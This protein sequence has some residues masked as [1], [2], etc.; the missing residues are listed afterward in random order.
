V[1][2]GGDYNLIDPHT[3][4]VVA[5]QNAAEVMEKIVGNA[6]R[7]GD[8]GIVFIDRINRDNPTP[9][10]GD[11]ES[12][13]PCGEQPLLPYESCNLG[14]INLVKFTKNGKIN[15]RELKRVVHSAV[16]F[17][18]NVIDMNKYPIEE[19]ENQTKANRKIGLGIMAFADMLVTLGI[20]YNSEAA[21]NI[22]EELMGFINKES[23]KASADLAKKR[24]AFPN[25]KGSIY[26]KPGAPK[27]RNATTT[28]IAPTGTISI[29][30]GVS[31]GIEPI[32]AVSYIRTVMDDDKL[33]EVHP[34]FERMAMDR[35]FYSKELMETIAFHGTVKDLEEVPKDIADLFITSHDVTPEWHL[36]MQAAFQKHT[37]NA[38]SKTVNF[39]NKATESEVEKS[40]ML[41]YHLG[42]KGVTIYRD[43]SRE[44]QV[45]ST[46]ST[47]SS[48]EDAPVEVKS[49]LQPKPRPRVISGKTVKVATGCGNIYVTINEDEAG[50]PFEV[51]T[52]IGKAGGC[53]ASQ[54]ES[55]GRLASLALRSG[56]NVDDVMSQ[57][58]GISCHQPAWE[59][60]GKVLSCADA[61][62]KAFM[63]YQE[64]K[65]A[66][67]A[68]LT[69][70][71]V[72]E[73]KPK[74]AAYSG[75]N[76]NKTN[77]LK[78]LAIG[79]CPDCGGSLEFAE[80]CLYCRSCGYSKCD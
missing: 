31:S 21:V 17:L 58:R 50:M 65:E 70:P 6:W 27:L 30:S 55:T 19:I 80:G 60:G 57:L 7:N 51:F 64:D 49:K 5:T 74:P 3:K 33:V 11:I 16:H 62:A 38:V 48:N 61:I 8:P 42:C 26:D 23:K 43:G 12:T 25:F 14:S 46:G 69:L 4:N 66:R 13:N 53:A 77:L 78:H 59:R 37:D 56:I 63:S 40:Y 29:I 34:I 35:G 41:A 22:A 45:L 72:E 68:Q 9:R 71:V 44:G 15:Y 73:A 36:R 2:K 54:T 18:D 1:E 32:F 20:P 39:P 28:T 24:G 47:G 79:A 76:G 75:G 52:Q 10:I 67:D